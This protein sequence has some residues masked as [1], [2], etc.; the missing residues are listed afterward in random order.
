MPS[1]QANMCLSTIFISKIFPQPIPSGRFT[2]YWHVCC[3]YRFPIQRLPGNWDCP[4]HHSLTA[5]AVSVNQVE[6]NWEDSNKRESG[7]AIERGQ[8]SS[9][10]F[11]GIAETGSDAVV[12]RG[13]R[14]TSGTYYYR[15][16]AFKN[17]R[18]GTRYSSYSS[19]VSAQIA[20]TT[21]PLVSISSGP[22][23][24]V[25]TSVQT[26]VI[27]ANASDDVGISHVEFFNNGVLIN[28]D[29]SFPYEYQWFVDGSSNGSHTWT[30]KAYDTAGN[31]DTSNTLI[32]SVDIDA[33]PPV[34]DLVNPTGG[35]T[36]IEPGTITVAADATDNVGVTM[37][38]FFDNGALIYTDQNAP[39]EFSWTFDDT[40]N[41]EHACTA[42]AF[43]TVGNSSESNPVVITVAIDNSDTT[44]PVAAITSPA[45]GSTYME[46]GTVTIA[47]AATDNVGVSKVN[48]Y[49]D[50]IL[51]HTAGIWI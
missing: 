31:S 3:Y 18:K 6:L 5:T 39:Y 33:T 22:A 23:D 47:A 12:Y 46:P 44:Q 19:T 14:L 37:V 25:H 42:K 8:S 48:F 13:Q 16:R 9:G 7:Y 21:P 4:R 34:V 35:S 20:D 24:A 49:L 28:L 43:D 10:P 29:S 50:G 30:V 41:G 45:D 17:S 40:D 32:C 15:L 1:V 11:L 51:V 27:Q 26:V 2:S 36:Y 38:Q